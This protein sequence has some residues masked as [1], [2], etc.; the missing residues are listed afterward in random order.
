MTTAQRER[1]ARAGG[2][3]GLPARRAVMRW[4]WRM[5][6]R[7]WRQQFLILALITAAV[8]ATVVGAAVQ[9]FARW[10][11]A[12]DDRYPVFAATVSLFLAGAA[13]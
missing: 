9:G 1:P 2:N 13:S 4:A 5:F 3:G 7:E 11:L 12:E 8:G 6:R 10:Y